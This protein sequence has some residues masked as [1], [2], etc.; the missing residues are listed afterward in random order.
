MPHTTANDGT[1]IHIHVEGDGPDVVLIHGWPLGHEMWKWQI[2]ALTE[3]G[4]RVIAHCR[5]G[6]GHS[7][8]A[9]GGYDYDIMTDDLAAVMKETDARDAALVGFSMG[10]GEVARY[11]SRHGGRNVSKAALVSAVTPFMLKTD[12]NPDGVPAETFEEMK[13]GLRDDRSAFLKDFA[14]DFYGQGSS[15]GGVSDEVLQWTH[16]LAMQA[17]EKATMDCVDAFGRTDFRPDMAAFSVPTLVIHGTADQTVPID[18]AGRAA[19][20]QIDG[21]ELKDYDGAPHG[22][23]ATHT[24]QLNA[25]LIAFLRG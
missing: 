9:G 1:K 17:S 24:D 22:L 23:F 18:T 14:K 4:F 15:G 13:Q 16:D 6:F 11:M 21:A 12:D 7:E 20:D 5:R 25:D 10:G 8:H 3:A 2:T 19:A